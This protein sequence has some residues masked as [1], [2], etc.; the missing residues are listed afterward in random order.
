M[1]ILQQSVLPLTGLKA[2]NQFGGAGVEIGFGKQYN[3]L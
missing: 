3:M 1:S 2:L